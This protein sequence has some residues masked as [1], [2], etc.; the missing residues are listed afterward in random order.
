MGGR[1]GGG[2]PNRIGG[3][4]RPKPPRQAPPTASQGVGVDA[5][6]AA[7]GGGGGGGGGAASAKA[8]R[9][10]EDGG[11]LSVVRG[12]NFKSALNELVMK[13]SG[14]PLTAVDVVYRLLP[15]QPRQ[16]KSAVKVLAIDANLDFEGFLRSGKREAEQ[17][18]A[19]TALAHYLGRLT[20]GGADAEAARLAV[21]G[22]GGDEDQAARGNYKSELNE[23][24]TKA[25]RRPITN[26]DVVYDT[27]PCSSGRTFVSTA[28]IYVAVGPGTDVVK[29]TGEEFARKKDA[30]QSAARMAVTHFMEV[31]LVIDETRL[32]A[33]RLDVEPASSGNVADHVAGGNFKSALN[34]L[35]MKA[36]GRA[37]VKDDVTYT[38]QL[39]PSGL[40]LVQV[41][42]PVLDPDATVAGEPRS[43]KKQAEQA[44]AQ[45]AL[46]HF[47]SAVVAAIAERAG[48]PAKSG[49]AIPPVVTSSRRV[50][51]AP[52]EAVP[53]APGPV[54]P[55]GLF[56]TAQQI[57]LA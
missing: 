33:L 44:A 46:A 45:T 2:A 22:G 35:I 19:R 1:G 30:E 25:M 26:Q 36:M 10:A 48:Q 3:P 7:C 29:F 24:V 40:F 57:G 11:A 9:C 16:F 23:I 39:Q 50:V 49:A 55:A 20:G 18:A 4:S 56:E 15:S 17:S 47:H 31:P 5:A 34:Q 37:L 53:Q 28:T 43:T 42:V 51:I 8:G 41:Q 14:R 54:L 38:A 32:R 52:P 12:E 6:S 13:I 27:R 21:A